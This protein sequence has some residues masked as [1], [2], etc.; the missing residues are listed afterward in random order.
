MAANLLQPSLT[1]I[2]P[3]VIAMTFDATLFTFAEPSGLVLEIP[4]IIQNQAWEQSQSFSTPASR[5]QAYLNQICLAA[6]LPWLREDYLSQAKPWPNLAAL[7]SFWELVNGFAIALNSTRFVLVP[8]ETIDLSELRVPQEWVDI[9]SWAGDYYLAAQVEP[10][11]GWIRVW[12]YCTHEKMKLRAQYDA[13]DR[14]YCL[15]ENDIIKDLSVLWVTKQLC[16]DEKTRAAI[17]PLSVLSLT[18]ADNLLQ[19]LGNP[20]INTP[21]VAIPFEMWAGLLEHGAWRQHLYERR[22]G[23][24]QQWSIFQWL[25]AEVS[26][27]AQQFGWGKIEFQQNFVGARGVEPTA[28][29][30]I[31]SRQLIIAGQ[32]YELRVVP[33]NLEEHIWRFELRNLGIDGLIPG[34]FKLRLLTEDLQ[35]FENNEDVAKTAQNLL[36]IEVSLAPGEGL[37]WETEPLPEH[38]DREILRFGD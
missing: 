22:I 33:I 12:G 17:Q 34:G 5:Y 3:G 29:N 28:Q 10:D 38:Y 14:T 35:E 2:F 27:F 32:Q 1:A 24:P 37:V 19:R 20:A 26:E 9:P 8:S 6:V 23:L 18:H 31:L 16:K 25:R 13:S 4:P 15:E 36:Y 7:P 30:A 11:E 21:R